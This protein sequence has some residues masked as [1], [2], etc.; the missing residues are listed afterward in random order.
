MMKKIMLLGAAFLVSL[1]ASAQFSGGDGSAENPFV[2]RTNADLKRLAEY[3][4]SNGD[5]KTQENW[6]K[7]RHFIIQT[8]SL[9]ADVAIGKGGHSGFSLNDGVKLKLTAERYCTGERIPEWVKYKYYTVMQVGTKRFPTGILLRE[10][11]SWVESDVLLNEAFTFQGTL[12]GKGNTVF[13]NIASGDTTQLFVDNN[14]EVKNLHVL[15]YSQKTVAKVTDKPKPVEVKPQPKPQPEDSVAAQ[16]RHR[17]THRTPDGFG[18]GNVIYVE[19]PKEQ[20]VD[21]IAKVMAEKAEHVNGHHQFA[22]GV[23][24]GVASFLHDFGTQ[25][26]SWEPGYVGMLDLQYA[27]YFGK[28]RPSLPSWGIRAGL[29]IGYAAS[30]A[31]TAVDDRFDVTDVDGDLIKYHVIADRV[32]ERDA[33]VQMEVSVMPS[34]VYNGLFINVGPKFLLPLYGHY[35]QKITN[36]SIE[37]YYEKYG[38]TVKDEVITGVLTEEQQLTK[39][40]WQGA[41]FDVMLGAEIGYEWALRNGNGVALGFY[42]D[43][44]VY[45]GYSSPST[46]GSLI[47][48]TQPG[49]SADAPQANVTVM[50]LNQKTAKLGYFDC[51]LK[52]TY[53]FNFYQK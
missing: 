42:A 28:K 46:V 5:V 41:K 52:L 48:L 7:G 19:K 32:R 34:F 9:V 33:R 24:G 13:V 22:V 4:N 31:Y 39:G 8:D 50:S 14:G 30:S 49:L 25:Q 43:Y 3:V 15:P 53:H 35:Q 6:S 17:P 36:P 18:G 21:S 16:E 1:A 29:G 45:S 47:Q 44:A 40:K 51:G 2:I 23:R 10:I 11:Y 27:Y 20:N 38:V 12:D 26:G 37:A